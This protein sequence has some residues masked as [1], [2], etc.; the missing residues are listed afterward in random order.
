[1]PNLMDNHDVEIITTCSVSSFLFLVSIIARLASRRIKRVAPTLICGKDAS[2]LARVR[3][4][5]T[6]MHWRCD[7]YMNSISDSVTNVVHIMQHSR[8]YCVRI[9]Q[10]LRANCAVRLQ[11]RIV[12]DN[13]STPRRS[14]LIPDFTIER[15]IIYQD[16]QS[17]LLK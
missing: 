10:F 16:S 6:K 4:N 11:L 15:R 2:N 17:M 9:E 12:Y 7:E 1:L 3:Q 5:L 14:R 13:N 8:Y